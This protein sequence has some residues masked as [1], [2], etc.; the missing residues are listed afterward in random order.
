MAQ[1]RL[2]QNRRRISYYSDWSAHQ[3]RVL[4][5]Q[6]TAPARSMRELG[7]RGRSS[8]DNKENNAH[9]SK[10]AL[11]L[12]QG[13]LVPSSSGT[14]SECRYLNARNLIHALRVMRQNCKL[15]RLPQYRKK[16]SGQFPRQNF[17]VNYVPNGIERIN[18]ASCS[19]TTS[20]TNKSER[21]NDGNDTHDY[22]IQT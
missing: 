19:D 7:R 17:A 12:I 5:L 22:D 6:V 9:N 2:C 3:A 15:C 14:R 13:R 21:A 20:V 10:D 1:M 11:T 16:P 4:R 18:E 8:S